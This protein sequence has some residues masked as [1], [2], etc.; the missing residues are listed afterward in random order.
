MLTKIPNQSI[1]NQIPKNLIYSWASE[2]EKNLVVIWEY[3]NYVQS[4]NKLG[5]IWEY[6]N[7]G[8]IEK[9]YPILAS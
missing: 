2:F 6:L 4:K 9:Y 7:L 1:P 3:I 8:A 5:A